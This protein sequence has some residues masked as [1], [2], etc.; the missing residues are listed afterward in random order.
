MSPMRMMRR[1]LLVMLVALA[2]SG[3]A[4]ADTFKIIPQRTVQEAVVLPSSSEPNLSTVL[5]PQVLAVP[6]DSQGLSWSQ[7]LPIWQGAA[8]AYG[9]PWS[10]LAAI[11]KIESNFGENMGPSSAGAIGWMQFMPSTWA[12]WGVDANGDGV[13]DPWNPTDAIYS[14]ARY[15]AAAGGAT[16]I[17]AAVYSY[18]HAQWYVDEVLQLAQGYDAGGADFAAALQASQETLANAKAAVLSANAALESARSELAPLQ[19]RADRLTRVA[20]AKTLLSDRLEAEKQAAIA[21]GAVAQAAGGRRCDELR[22]RE[23]AVR[24][25]ERAGDSKHDVR[26]RRRR[27]VFT[28]VGRARRLRLPGRRRRR[29]SSSVGHTHHDYPA[30]DIMAPEGTQVYALSNGTVKAVYTDGN[31][32]NGFTID[33]TDGLSWTYCHMAVDRQRRRPRR[34]AERRRACRPGRRDGARNRAA[35]PSAAQ[36]DRRVPAGRA[37]V[38]GVRR[39]RV[40][41]VER[42]P[43][44]SCARHGLH[45]L[46]RGLRSRRGRR[47]ELQRR[48]GDTLARLGLPESHLLHSN[49]GLSFPCAMPKRVTW[50][51]C[52]T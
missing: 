35:S 34:L 1:I 22:S 10:V 42:R 41:L 11:N 13:A 18:N 37:V 39:H 33:T 23:S 52:A 8:Q 36:P 50:D 25:H 38:P 48:L 9:V 47:H 28:H 27:T 5:L 12:R 20:A 21:A 31:C 30:A 40:Q 19:A 46:G 26:L 51:A 17:A 44:E 32:G 14:A 16:N 2:A 49:R 29:A 45:R 4:S 3:A 6:Q 24:A 7:L 15:L 43:V